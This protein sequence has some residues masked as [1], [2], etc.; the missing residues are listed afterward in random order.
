M[1][2][3]NV[4][5]EPVRRQPRQPHLE[6]DAHWHADDQAPAFTVVRGKLEPLGWIP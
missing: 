2:C 4:L 3:V 6:N 5:P 1:T